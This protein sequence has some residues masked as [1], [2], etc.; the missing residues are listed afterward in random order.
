[1]LTVDPWATDPAA[2]VHAADCRALEAFYRDVISGSECGM[3][4]QMLRTRYTK[5][6][7][8]TYPERP[9]DDLPSLASVRASG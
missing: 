8:E 6:T 2:A 7:G 3:V 1:M 4:R 9:M 5:L